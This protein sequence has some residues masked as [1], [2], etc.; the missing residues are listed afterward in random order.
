MLK[1]LKDA[2]RS[3]G[4]RQTSSF[5]LQCFIS[6]YLFN[7][8][9]IPK[10]CYRKQHSS[11]V[12][13]EA[14][15]KVERIG[16][17]YLFFCSFIALIA[18]SALAYSSRRTVRAGRISSWEPAC[19][20]HRRMLEG[21]LVQLLKDLLEEHKHHLFILIGRHEDSPLWFL[22]SKYKCVSGPQAEAWGCSAVWF[23][24]VKPIS[25]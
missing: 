11:F 9:Q 17:F 16:A 21:R 2:A 3:A 5:K 14:K 23:D 19:K 8:F 7:S 24:I 1:L 4:L 18:I 15:P 25:H 6:G 22:F 20:F 12:D 10:S 13:R